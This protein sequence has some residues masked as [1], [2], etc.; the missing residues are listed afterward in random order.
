MY[1]ISVLACAFLIKILSNAQTGNEQILARGFSF[2]ICF[3]FVTVL[4]LIY[5]TR[6]T[7]KL[8]LKLTLQLRNYK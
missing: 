6:E 4:V 7:S 1:K 2:F 8:K 3:T 5:F